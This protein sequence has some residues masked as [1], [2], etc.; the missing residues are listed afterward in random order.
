MKRIISILAALCV[1]MS[2]TGCQQSSQPVAGPVEQLPDAP[3]VEVTDPGS[4]LAAVY[5]TVDIMGIEPVD[6]RV[7]EEK[8]FLEVDRLEEYYVRCSSG[9]FGLADV[10]ILMPD[11]DYLAKA[12]EQLE[13]I[14]LMRAREFADYDIY[15]AHQIALD[16]VI[17][18]QGGYLI[19]L[20]LPD[21]DAARKVID[22]YIPKN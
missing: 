7:L 11:A 14:K 6:E 2:A 3:V 21:N 10:F 19:M 22:Q 4:A 9:R 8:F 20:M 17:Y 13:Q 16:A 5:E 12:R 18:E 1:G 15:D